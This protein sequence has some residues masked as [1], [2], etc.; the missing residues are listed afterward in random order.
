VP[1]Q[2]GLHRETL[3]WET[4]QIKSSQ[5]K[6][7]NKNKNKNKSNQTD[8]RC[9]EQETLFLFKQREATISNCSLDLY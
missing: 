5:N 3:S 7:K 1:G 9:P 2:P 4:N 8:S 6:I